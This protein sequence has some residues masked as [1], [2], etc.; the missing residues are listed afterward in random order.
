[1]KDYLFGRVIELKLYVPSSSNGV[2]FGNEFHISFT[3][4][5]PLKGDT[6]NDGTVTIYN[7][8]KTSRD[9][10]EADDAVIELYTGYQDQQV[11]LMMS[12][13]VD[14]AYSRREGPDWI[15]VIN[16][17]EGGKDIR[18]TFISKSYTNPVNDKKVIDDVIGNF[19]T[20]EKGTIKG[21]TDS[22]KKNGL[23]IS[24]L[25]KGVLNNI[26]STHKVDWTVQD[27]KLHVLPEKGLI[28]DFLV[29][30]TP[31]TGLIGTPTKTRSQEKGK[32]VI[33][34]CDITCLI[35]PGIYPGRGIKLTSDTVSGTYKV[36]NATYDGSNFEDN[37]TCTLETNEI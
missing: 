36:I 9:L 19:K 2:A 30:L 31:Q 10:W 14:W 13:D 12:A 26:A 11:S 28:T 22:V 1:M 23:S 25:T 33:W 6:P 32:A 24:S 27:N 29:E 20:V 7:L 3:V 35:I 15:T 34:G 16:F 8:N 17:S 37:W 5:K 21:L 18:D 4:K